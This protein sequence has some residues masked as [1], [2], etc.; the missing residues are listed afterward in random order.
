MVSRKLLSLVCGAVLLAGC[1]QAP[2][3]DTPLDYADEV[4]GMMVETFDK[5]FHDVRLTGTN[6]LHSLIVMQHGKVIYEK[7]AT[8]QEPDYLHILWSASKTFTS[9]AIGFAQQEGLLNLDDKV[10]SFFPEKLPADPALELESLTVRNLLMMSSGL[11][12]DTIGAIEAGDMA[13]P[14]DS[15]LAFGFRFAPG[16]KFKYNSCNTYLLSAIITKLTG[17]TVEEYLTSRL[18]EP[19]GIYDHIW[20]VSTEG[21]SMGGWGL[22]ITTRS[23]AKM[24]Q[25]Y[26][27]RGVW[28]GQRLLEEKWFDEATAARIDSSEGRV[29]PDWVAGYGYQLWRCSVPGS[30]RLDGAWG[31][32]SIVIPD[33]DAVVT[34]NAHTRDVQSVMT[35]IWKNIYPNL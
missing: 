24:G 26:L 27:Q 17:Q 15:I 6:E 34:L 33:K 21:C 35:S 18:F 4:D 23:F 20:E 32:L 14:T 25:F 16:E 1:A 7:Y 10:V 8:G 29:N 30:F 12:K 13:S 5:V 3:C 22:H 9:T 11:D 28:N 19:L 2:K 31:Q